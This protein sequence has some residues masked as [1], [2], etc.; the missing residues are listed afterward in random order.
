MHKNGKKPADVRLLVQKKIKWNR[1]LSTYAVL[2]GVMYISSTIYTS[3][4]QNSQVQTAEKSEKQGKNNLVEELLTSYSIPKI[5]VKKI[6]RTSEYDFIVLSQFSN[7][8]ERISAQKINGGSLA[9]I[10]ED[11][12]LRCFFV[13]RPLRPEEIPVIR[14]PTANEITKRIAPSLRQVAETGRIDDRIKLLEETIKI[15]QELTSREPS[16]EI[17]M[18]YIFQEL[19]QI[20]INVTGSISSQIRD[21]FISSALHEAVHGAYN[22]DIARKNPALFNLLNTNIV[23]ND[24]TNAYILSMEESEALA[25]LATLTYGQNLLILVRDLISKST[26]ELIRGKDRQSYDLLKKLFTSLDL[27]DPL[28]LMD[29]TENEIRSAARILL[30]KFSI[31][32]YKYSFDAVVNQNSLDEIKRKAEEYFDQNRSN[33]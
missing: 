33:L 22:R 4:T 5:E 24:N 8:L 3:V 19:L 28:Y 6:I 21:N 18:F 23:I 11:A 13:V 12:Y 15:A 26:L 16:K 9:L 20:K 31:E 30:E 32:H 29:K 2:A 1:R 14:D 25:R 17:M 27:S 7:M 10:K